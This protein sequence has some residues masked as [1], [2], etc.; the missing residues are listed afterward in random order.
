MDSQNSTW[1]FELRIDGMS[2]VRLAV[3]NKKKI[4]L[5]AFY[6]ASLKHGVAAFHAR[7]SAILDRD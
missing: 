4:D 1:R 3:L 6:V 2:L 7:P 5:I